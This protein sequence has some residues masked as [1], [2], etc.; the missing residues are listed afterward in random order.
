VT[1]L[2]EL[3]RDIPPSRDLWPDIE[4]RL[5]TTTRNVMRLPRAPRSRSRWAELTALAAMV[6]LLSIGIWIGHVL[7]PV[8]REARL[9]TPTR[10]LVDSRSYGLSDP[11]YM[12]VRAQLLRS[13]PE[14]LAALPPDSRTKVVASLKTIQQAMRDI[15]DALRQ[16]SANAVLQE[17]LI[18]TCQD[19]MRVLTAVQEAS[20]SGQE[21]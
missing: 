9:G 13:L 21:I 1:R 6:A 12:R 14:K 7:W 15:L 16:D 20:V 3:A 17:L 5:S 10:D 11:R 8:G 19:E 18:S 2:E 4:A